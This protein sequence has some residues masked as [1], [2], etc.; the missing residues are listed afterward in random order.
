M[1]PGHAHLGDNRD[2]FALGIL[3]VSDAE[4]QGAA[5]RVLVLV[6]EEQGRQRGVILF[7][8][9]VQLDVGVIKGRSRAELPATT[10]PVVTDRDKAIKLGAIGGAVF[11]ALEAGATC[12]IVVPAASGRRVHIE[13]AGEVGGV[14]AGLALIDIDAAIV[15]QVSLGV[16][17]AA[18]DTEDEVIGHA[19]VRPDRE[20]TRVKSV[21]VHVG[22]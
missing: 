2:S 14:N 9:A 16:G 22:I 19:V 17:I 20:P 7:A 13:A 3:L 15:D 4:A 8:E 21:A 12:F 6:G 1:S 11:V 5:G 10:R 18:V